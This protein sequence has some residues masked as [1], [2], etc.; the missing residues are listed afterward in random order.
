MLRAEITPLIV[1]DHQEPPEGPPYYELIEGDLEMSPAPDRV[2]Q[3]IL[4]KISFLL[5]EFL[6]R[7]PLGEIYFAPVDV[8]LTDL[9]VYQPDLVFISKARLSI[10][11]DQGLE[12]AP[13]LVVEVLS[14]KTAKLDRE[15]KGEVY[16]CTGVK[17]LWIVDPDLKEVHVYHL[18]KS[19]DRPAGVYRARQS[20]Q[21]PLL[22]GLRISVAKF[23]AK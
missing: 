6:E 3:A 1:H 7:E 19:V 22:P 8:F 4:R 17:E 9:N 11:T 2:H 10:L 12:R 20:F 14:P 16:A 23:F 21:S 5:W 18:A 15:I 13:D